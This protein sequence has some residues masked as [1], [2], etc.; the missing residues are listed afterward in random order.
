[1]D[2]DI[3]LSKKCSKKVGNISLPGFLDSLREDNF[4]EFS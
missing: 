2:T 1:M 3:N 4:T